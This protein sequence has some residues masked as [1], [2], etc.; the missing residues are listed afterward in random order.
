MTTAEELKQAV[1]PGGEYSA[2][3]LKE[4]ATGK[5]A[6]QDFSEQFLRSATNTLLIGGPQGESDN[7]RPNLYGDTFPDMTGDPAVDIF[8]I[9]ESNTLPGRMGGLAGLAAVFAPAM[10]KLMT[11]VPAVNNQFIPGAIRQGKK[12]LSPGGK[13]PQFIQNL[14]NAMGNA[15]A[16][17][18][19][20]LT[21]TET[22]LGASA[23]A[24]GYAAT[25]LFPDSPAAEVVGELIGGAGPQVAYSGGKA[26][27]K[28]TGNLVGKLPSVRWLLN[29]GKDV[30]RRIEQNT[31]MGPGTGRAIE[32]IERA[33]PDTQGAVDAIGE[34]TVGNLSPAA[35][36]G[37]KGLLSLER[38]ILNE[39]DQLTRQMDEDIAATNQAIRESLKSEGK[40][41]VTAQTFED[42]RGYLEQLVATR[43]RIAGRAADEKIANLSPTASREQANRI[44]AKEVEKALKDV[45]EQENALYRL[46][47]MDE[48]VPSSAATRNLQEHVMEMGAAQQSDIPAIAKRFLNPQSNEYLGK[49]TT[50]RELRGVQSKLRE[51]ARIARSSG[52]YN[53][54]RI[55][56]DIANAITNDIGAAEGSEA[57]QTAVAFSRGLNEKFNKR[58]LRLITGTDSAGARSV[59][60]ALALEKTLGSGP[61][62]REAYDELVGALDG[63]VTPELLGA[64]EDVIADRFLRSSMAQGQLNLTAAR[65]FATKNGDILDRLPGLKSKIDDAIKSGDTVE[66]RGRQVNRLDER[67]SKAM[68]FTRQAPEKAFKSIIDSRTPARDIQNLI[69][70]AERDKSGQAL[71]GLRASFLEYVTKNAEIPA[72]DANDVG[73]ISGAKL[74]DL[75]SNSNVDVMVKRLLP[76]DQQ[77]RLKVVVNTA[78]KLDRWRNAKPSKEGVLGDQLSKGAEMIAGVLGAA[79]GRKMGSQMGIGGTVQIPGIMADRF[80]QLLRSGVNNPARQLL[81][82]AIQDEELFKSVLMA[83]MV[84]NNKLPEKATKRLN[85]WAAGLL[86]DRTI[87]EE[88]Q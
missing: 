49:T 63:E 11:Q 72:T 83:K 8:G 3:S 55:A 31:T 16:K 32:R 50:I 18:P 79:Y 73:F 85:A 39:S 9:E 1:D 22:A 88:E 58:T 4:A 21:A 2:A 62:A 33:T 19:K 20:T 34:E 24:V 6:F 86:E 65:N 75:L 37:D 56:D 27:I 82:D 43:L 67:K 40:P 44:A 59:P 54:A 47:P 51:A 45:R 26:A 66:L 28:G 42:A 12:M 14:G 53:R 48:P 74:G 76:K 70:Q 57:V 13:V 71:E 80:R 41:E 60:E 38:S 7:G 64:V 84:D 29:Q 46:V 69:N 52:K 15:F 81:E 77:S 61:A 10:G 36:T 30:V 87:T 35:K 78:K 68:L 23:G 5:G 17:S 25:Q